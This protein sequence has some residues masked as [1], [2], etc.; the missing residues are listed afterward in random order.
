MALQ[1]S[2]NESVRLVCYSPEK[3]TML[4]QSQE[5]QL[6]V[7]ITSAWMSPNKRF[8]ATDEYTI[9]KKAKIMQTSLEFS[10]N[11]DLG[12]RYVLVEDALKADLYQT[13]DVE[14]KVL[15]K[16]PL[17]ET[18]FQGNCTKCKTDVIV[19]DHTNSTK[20]VLWEDII[21]KV[22]SGKSYQF[23][24]CKIRIFDDHKYIN[25]NEFTKIT[26][27]EDIKNVN[28]LSPQIQENMIPAKCMGVE[29]KKSSSC[30]LWRK[31]DDSQLQKETMKCQNCHITILSNVAKTK[32]VCQLLLQ[33][34][35]KFLTYNA[36]NDSIQSFLKNIGCATSAA[37]LGEKELTIKVL[38][39]RTQ[40]IMV[41]KAARMISYF[42][43]SEGSQTKGATSETVTSESAKWKT[44]ETMWIPN[45]YIITECAVYM[46]LPP[47]FFLIVKILKNLSY[48]SV[49]VHVYTNKQT[50]RISIEFTHNYWNK[51]ELIEG[52]HIVASLNLRGE[53]AKL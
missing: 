41:D 20:L 1:T 17:K 38:S 14:V 49:W 47:C 28:L 50:V 19:A 40:K 45:H 48:Q 36:F 21:D 5:K 7:K 3:R 4:P 13:V 12:N 8:S 22:D 15:H 18:L 42:L 30:I 46:T 27:I 25:T 23:N 9:S 16:S 32:L 11:N 34:D 10:Y 24:N 29:V 31:L 44:L 52:R 39:A 26:E 37:E 6:P 43:P 51:E 2:Q 53:F 33:V 35:N